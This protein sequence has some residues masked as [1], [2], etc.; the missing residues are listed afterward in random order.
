MPK[1][2]RIA[3]PLL[4]LASTTLA[5]GAIVYGLL[6]SEAKRFREANLLAANNQATTVVENIGLTVAEVKTAVMESLL[7]FEGP[8]FAPQLST[9]QQRDPLV[10]FAFS[11]ETSS[12]DEVELFPPNENLAPDFKALIRP[13]KKGWIWEAP[14]P[15]PAA[16]ESLAFADESDALAGEPSFYNY[17]S[18]TTLR[19]EIRSQSQRTTQ[20]AKSSFRKSKQAWVSDSTRW[21]HDLKEGES[22]WI[23]ISSWNGG[24]VI[25]GAVVRLGDLSSI[26]QKSFPTELAANIESFIIRDPSGKS[27]AATN[28]RQSSYLRSERLP[29]GSAETFSLG[30]E[31][32]GWTLHLYTQLDG[33][34]GSMITSAAGLGTTAVLLTLFGT[35]IWLVWQTRSSQIEAARKVSFVSNVS[36]EL[37]TPLTTIRMYS[38]LLQTGRVQDSEKRNKYLDTISGECQRLTRLVNNVLDFS[39]LDQSRVKLSL[40]EQELDPVLRSY[41]ELRLRDLARHNFELETDLQLGNMKL[42]F[43]RDA[44]CQIFGNLIDNSLKYARQGAWIRIRSRQVDNRAL[45]EF[46]DKG[47]GLP[48]HLRKKNFQAFTRGDD[49]LTA[50]TSGF[51][52]GLSIAQSLADEMGAKLSYLHPQSPD[53]YP[54]FCLEFTIAP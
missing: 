4:L 11:W 22:Y 14:E 9:W 17:A 40:E 15:S 46:S 24:Q 30:S 1:K 13:Q 26:L 37:K 38:E 27:V 33:S 29:S 43:D 12:P 10:S 31:L 48:A 36:H 49:S 2:P 5:I 7:A 8:N 23:G 39:R 34:L 16:K 18:N 51:G 25:T 6:W 41:L 28:S 52:L 54:T 3:L 42:H 21:I 44:L 32:P 50:E 19:Q 53:L 45:I 47:A 20:V 35:G